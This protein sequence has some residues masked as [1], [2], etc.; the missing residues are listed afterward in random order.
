MIKNRYDKNG[1]KKIEPDM[2]DRTVA[3][4]GAIL[5]RS[6]VYHSLAGDGYGKLSTLRLCLWKPA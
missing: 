3:Q 2:A 1:Q 6:R 5:A 4:N